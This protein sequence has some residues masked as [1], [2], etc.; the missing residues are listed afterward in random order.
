MLNG[1]LNMT[2]CCDSGATD[3]TIIN[4][5]SNVS[6]EPDEVV[7]TMQSA[8]RPSLDAPMRPTPAIRR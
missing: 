4:P 2:V 7:V 6:L 5:A 3:S 1:H 8:L